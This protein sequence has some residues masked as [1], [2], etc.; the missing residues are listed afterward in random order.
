MPAMWKPQRARQLQQLSAV[1]TPS[2]S[3]CQQLYYYYYYYYY[4]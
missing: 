4:Y 3:L 1:H 2:T